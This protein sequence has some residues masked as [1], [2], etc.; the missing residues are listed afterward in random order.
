[1][2]EEVV[3]FASEASVRLLL[4]LE[5][6]VARKN[7]RRLVTLTTELDARAALHAP[8]NVDVQN[9][10]VHN[11][12]LARATLAAILVLDDLSLSVAVRAGSL[13]TLD[14]GTHLSHHSLHAVT[15]TTGTLLDGA[16]LSSATLALRADDGPLEGQLRDLAAVDIL[17]RDLVG[18]VD[19]ARLGRALLARA[20]AATAKHATES[21]ATTKELRKQILGGHATT[22]AGGAI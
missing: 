11:S 6:H 22:T 17:E 9:L 5:N 4:D 2:V 18:V 16:F 19:G 15:V 1:M 13:E 12:L 21:T 10:A 14:H 7:T 8:I 20:T 3:V